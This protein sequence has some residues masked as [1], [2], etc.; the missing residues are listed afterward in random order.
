MFTALWAVVQ[1]ACEDL[2]GCDWQW[3]A[4]DGGPLAITVAGANVPDAQLLAGA[5]EAVVLELPEPE[6]EFEQHC[7][8]DKGYDNDTGWGAPASTTA[9]RLIS[10]DPRRAPGPAQDPQTQTPGRRTNAGLAL[11][12]SRHPRPLGE[13]SP[14]L[15]RPPPVRLWPALVPSLRPSHRYVRFFLGLRPLPWQ[16]RLNCL[17]AFIRKQIA[18]LPA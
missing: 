7:C 10:P 17:P 12:M 5:I 1:E 9:T 14:E 3:Q 15:P 2:G 18:Y 6:P 13:E 16:S 4:A 11:E 8:L